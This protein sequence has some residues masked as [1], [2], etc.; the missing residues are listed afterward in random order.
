MTEGKQFLFQLVKMFS[1]RPMFPHLDNFM[2]WHP[3]KGAVS[4]SARSISSFR[5]Q[6]GGF[7][8]RIHKLDTKICIVS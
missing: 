1:V 5:I 3:F 6:Y 4:P 7:A 8:R 2:N